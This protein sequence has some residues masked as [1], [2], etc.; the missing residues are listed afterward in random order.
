MTVPPDVLEAACR[1]VAA[2]HYSRRFNKSP[3]DPHVVMNVNSNWQIFMHDTKIALEAGS[4]SVEK[5]AA[6]PL[7]DER[8]E[9]LRTF[10]ASLN[11]CIDKD[12]LADMDVLFAE[13]TTLRSQHS[14]MT[15][16][17]DEAT[18]QWRNYEAAAGDTLA[19][20]EAAERLSARQLE[21]LKPFSDFAAFIAKHHPGWDHD[22]FLVFGVDHAD[23]CLW[24]APFRL[25]ASLATESSK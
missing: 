2:D 11:W 10:V 17:R 21:A 3:H 14:E 5:S 13:L 15:A 19:R 25:V 6:G 7:P 20:A 1:A 9:V 8:V 18:R 12:D 23:G 16:E 4:S 22:K 24:M